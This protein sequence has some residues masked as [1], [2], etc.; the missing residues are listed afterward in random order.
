M[1]GEEVVQVYVSFPDSE[2]PM[3][4]ERLCAFDRVAVKAGETVTVSLPVAMEAI[5]YWDEEQA[6]FVE[7]KQKKFVLH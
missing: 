2:V 5:S 6:R 4:W 3:P 7:A 1:Y